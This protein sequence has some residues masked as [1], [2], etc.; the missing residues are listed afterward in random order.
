M[1]SWYLPDEVPK[2]PITVLDR[3]KPMAPNLL[4]IEFS[5]ALLC[6]EKRKR[7][8]LEMILEFITM[9]EKLPIAYEPLA[10]KGSLSRIITLSRQYKLTAYDAVYLDMAARKGLPLLTNDR[11]LQRAAKKCGLPIFEI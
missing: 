8:N 6:A 9:F 2:Y 7:I 4:M 11:A 3:S 5:N 1:G 10:S